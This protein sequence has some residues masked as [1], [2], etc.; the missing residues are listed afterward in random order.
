[1]LVILFNMNWLVGGKTDCLEA[2]R[3]QPVPCMNVYISKQCVQLG[4]NP[5]SRESNG[6]GVILLIHEFHCTAVYVL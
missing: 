4:T 5:L 6:V 1:M 2:K 3:S